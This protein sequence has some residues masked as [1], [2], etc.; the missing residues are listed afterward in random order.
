MQIITGI[1]PHQWKKSTAVTLGKFDG[2][3]RGHQKLVNRIMEYK[4]PECDSVLCAFDMGR[5]SL[6]TKD[7]RRKRLEGKIDYL[8]EYR[9]TKEL[10]EMEAEDF[11]DQILC[12]NFHAS[13]IV[14]GTDFSFGYR[15]KGDAAMLAAFAE[16]RGYTLD[17]IEKER[18]QGRVISSSYIR[19][20][21]SRGEVE[22]AG[23]LLGYPY[24]MSGVVE[25]GRR[26][27]RTLG[28]PTMNIEPR[29]HKI[30]PRFGVYACRV[31]IGGK[32]YDAIGNAG[33]KP[34]VTNEHKRL[35]EVFVFGYEGDTYGK[36]IRV[37]FCT[38]E[39]PET[40]FDSVE[41]LKNQVM[42]DI[43]FGE[44]YFGKI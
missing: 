7:E 6:M 30:L 39:R 10:R 35:L 41:E 13:H 9:F 20:A 19:E 36:E 26:L 42:R 15:K 31:Q 22:L 33:I 27:G 16:S 37:Q 44:E 23:E 4:S 11:I 34:T 25:H 1:E 40:K 18:Y 24:E 14:V 43:R 17:V 29:E 2:L 21:L 12:D 3:H 38:F 8:V 5:E 32:W 28:F